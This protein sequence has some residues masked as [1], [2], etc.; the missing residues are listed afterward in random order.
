[1]TTVTERVLELKA[2]VA[3][4]AASEL[5]STWL[6]A[7]KAIAESG[8]PD[9]EALLREAENLVAALER[10]PG[11]ELRARFLALEG[12]LRVAGETPCWSCGELPGRG[13]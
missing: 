5:R 10:G 7:V 2:E 4:Q 3:R 1:M 6:P 9:A 11:E 13:P 8:G 12:L